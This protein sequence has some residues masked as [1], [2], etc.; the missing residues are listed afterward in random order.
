MTNGGHGDQVK[1]PS[2][3][4]RHAR[5]KV[6]RSSFEWHGIIVNFLD[7][8]MKRVLLRGELGD[9]QKHTR[10]KQC[11]NFTGKITQIFFSVNFAPVW[12]ECR[13]FEKVKG[14][15]VAFSCHYTVPP[16]R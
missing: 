12:M 10:P 14:R 6:N 15:N 4:V 7:V 11:Q 8:R 5:R 1:S 16:S 9:I 2:P 13:L 3:G